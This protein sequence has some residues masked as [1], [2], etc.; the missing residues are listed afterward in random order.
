MNKALQLADL[1]AVLSIAAAVTVFFFTFEAAYPEEANIDLR[2]KSWNYT[3]SGASAVKD[4]T[5]TGYEY[6]KKGVKYFADK[7]KDVTASAD[8]TE[9]IT[10]S[11]SD[12]TNR[13]KDVVA[14]AY[15]VV[16]NASGKVYGNKDEYMRSN[17]VKKIEKISS[18]EELRATAKAMKDVVNS[19]TVKKGVGVLNEKSAECMKSK[20]CR[21]VV[22]AGIYA[23]TGSTVASG[24]IAASGMTAAG[25]VGGGAG[26]GTAAGPVGAVAGATVGLAVYGI[27]KAFSDKENELKKEDVYK[28]NL[29]D[30]NR[31]FKEDG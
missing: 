25:M 13:V 30:F 31:G 29:A 16:K 4:K 24:L 12:F 15:S 6:G 2:E 1:T 19:D 11:L 8:G 27:I 5:A 7:V 28:R 10:V 21:D 23:G 26:I 18:M 3:K 22:S 14:S 9:E 17:A 20:K